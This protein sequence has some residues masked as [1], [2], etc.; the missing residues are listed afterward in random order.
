MQHQRRRDGVEQLGVVNAEYHGPTAATIDN[1]STL[2]RISSSVSSVRT[3]SGSSPASAPSGTVAALL[4]ACTQS[5]TAPSPT[6]AAHASRA[7][8]D[9]PTPA[10]AL[11]T[12]PRQSGSALACAIRANSSSRP[13]NGHRSGLV[14]DPLEASGSAVVR[15]ANGC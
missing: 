2:R 6:A 10:F 1:T 11:I 7:S 15:S 8:L 3:S 5:T 9:F 14:V 13:I 4:V 12:T